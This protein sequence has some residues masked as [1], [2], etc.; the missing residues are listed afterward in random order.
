MSAKRDETEHRDA[1]EEGSVKRQKTR[2][3]V[4]PQGNLK[5][6]NGFY[7]WKKLTPSLFSDKY[8]REC[9]VNPAGINTYFH[10]RKGVILLLKSGVVRFLKRNPIARARDFLPNAADCA[11]DASEEVARER[12]AELLFV[13]LLPLLLNRQDITTEQLYQAYRDGD[14]YYSIWRRS[15][16]KSKELFLRDEYEP[17]TD[18]DRDV[19]STLGQEV[20][21]AMDRYHQKHSKQWV[22]EGFS[23]AASSSSSSSSSIASSSS[24]QSE[25]VV[26]SGPFAGLHFSVPITAFDSVT[27]SDCRCGGRALHYCVPCLIFSQPARSIL[28]LTTD[29]GAMQLP[30]SVDL[31][32]NPREKLTKSTGLHSVLF[33]PDFARLLS[34][35]SQV[36][37]YDPETT[38]IL[39]PSE[40]ARYFDDPTLDISR[41]TK[42]VFIESTWQGSS[43][44]YGSSNLSALPHVK[45]RPRETRFWRTQHLGNECL[46]TIEA[47]YY[48]IV[49]FWKRMHPEADRPPT[50]WDD[51]LL[52][53][54]WQHHTITARQRKPVNWRAAE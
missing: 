54:A 53:F 32:H 40:K 47:V 6:I 8:I 16:P 33:A 49:D 7:H 31:I 10:L 34:F 27:R 1:D 19:K 11:S 25:D 9:L 24:Q 44:V 35:P 12:E 36:P 15:D 41:V 50:D 22:A 28:G 51:L 26:A 20:R 3:D 30:V 2:T 42:L 21:V 48:A 43:S 23:S 38:L 37:E 18:R 4:H 17:H 5:I 46:A 39:F 45:L 29:R 13:Y 14:A 52:F